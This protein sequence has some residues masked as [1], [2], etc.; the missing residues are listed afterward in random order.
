MRVPLHC[1]RGCQ[2]RMPHW[3]RP[4]LNIQWTRLQQQ[5]QQKQQRCRC[6]AAQPKQLLLWPAPLRR[7]RLAQALEPVASAGRPKAG[8][9][10]PAGTQHLSRCGSHLPQNPPR[11]LLP[12]PWW[13][14]P[15]AL[16]QQLLPQLLPRRAQDPVEPPRS[17]IVLWRRLPMALQQHPRRALWG[18]VEEKSQLEPQALVHLLY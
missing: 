13:P 4:Y 6:P 8:R 11:L 1:I 12:A 17:P 18:C 9:R 16:P 5:Q 14:P 10:A 7:P 15:T 3:R 2:N